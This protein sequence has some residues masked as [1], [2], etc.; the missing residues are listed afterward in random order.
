MLE[1]FFN[2]ISKFHHYR[3]SL[4]SKNLDFNNLIDIGAHE[5]EFLESFLKIKKIKRF[6]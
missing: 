1:T 4:Y 5:G 2:F 3:I 6:Y